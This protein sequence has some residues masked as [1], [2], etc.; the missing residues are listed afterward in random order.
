MSVI[1]FKIFQCIQQVINH[2]NSW[3]Y[4]GESY[5][6]TDSNF[7]DAET[8]IHRVDGST[9]STAIL[10]GNHFYVAN[11]GDSRAVILKAGK[12]AVFFIVINHFITFQDKCL[13]TL[14]IIAILVC[15]F[16]FATNLIVTS[17]MEHLKYF[18]SWS[19]FCIMSGIHAS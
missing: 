6:K 1:Y 13:H 4:P 15:Y 16:K 19:L 17:I 2:T 5:M 14:P 3:Y 8:N 11:V 7:L 18:Q 10:I 12:G 9:A